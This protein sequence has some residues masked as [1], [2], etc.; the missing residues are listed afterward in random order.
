MKN[1]KST[2]EKIIA[3]IA[4]FLCGFYTFFGLSEFYKIGIKKRTEFYPF[5]TEGPVPYY[6]H[7]AELY[8]Y[9]NLIYGI[10]FGILMGT[11]IWNWKK[12]KISGF[13]TFKL[14]VILILIHICHGS[15]E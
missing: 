1:E 5:G 9:V 8:S 15:V 7:S 6:Y 10:A 12:N 4:I 13:T 14:T 3:G 2:F 11:T